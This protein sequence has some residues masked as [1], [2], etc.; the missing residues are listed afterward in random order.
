MNSLTVTAD[1]LDALARRLGTARFPGVGDSLFDAVPGTYHS[2]ISDHILA[3]LTARGMIAERDGRI[4][5][6]PP[7]AALLAPTL[8]GAIRYEI[9]RIE[10]AGTSV[11]ALSEANGMVVW[12]RAEGLYH[13]FDLI[14]TDGDI[15]RV[16]AELLDPAEG[17]A[18]T[19]PADVHRRP[20]RRRRS[21][22]VAA[23]EQ[24]QAV[25]ATFAAL[26]DH[27]RATT[28]ICQLGTLN[29]TP[30]ASWFTVVDGGQEH[31]WLVETDP[32]STEDGLLEADDP[33]L[34]V[35]P[36]DATALRRHLDRWCGSV[37]LRP[38]R[39]GSNVAWLPCC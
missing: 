32:D 31:W 37:A 8:R 16:L 26:A 35:I 9:E 14:G 33:M 10:P 30:A 17:V 27:W 25:P 21:A 15:A 2:V 12:H 11:T 19:R 29:G 39:A 36:L 28:T 13:R 38:D 34:A 6:S 3:G 1:E 7:V 20:F 23:A 4:V 22:L 5:A 24:P 18:T